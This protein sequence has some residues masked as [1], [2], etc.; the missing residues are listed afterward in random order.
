[1]ALNSSECLLTLL[2]VH[3]CIQTAKTN[4]NPELRHV[5]KMH[6]MQKKEVLALEISAV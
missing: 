5:E 1:M 2:T 3:L 6:G 4:L